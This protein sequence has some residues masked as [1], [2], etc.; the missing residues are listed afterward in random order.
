MRFVHRI[1][2]RASAV[3]RRVLEELALK[4]PTGASLP[5]GGEKL[6][7]FDVAE[8][9]PNWDRLAQLFLEW[10]VSDVLRTEFSKEDLDAARWLE[11]AAWH[12]GYP[13]PNEGTFGYRRATYDLSAWCE[14]CGV[15]KQQRAPFQMR[16]E[17]KWAGR[18]L[19]QLVWV[20]D[21]LFA[22]PDLWSRA[23]EPLGLAKRGVFNA[24]GAEL[25]TVVQVCVP[26]LVHV[27][28]GGLTAE[29]CGA[30]NREKFH[31]VARGEFPALREAPT[32]PMARTHEYFGSGAQADRRL[33]VSRDV[34]RALE[35]A[36]AR[37]AVLRPVAQGSAAAL[38]TGEAV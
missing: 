23:F 5:G 1:G 33:I 26:E 34:I 20:Y 17:P 28:Q 24:A 11:I 37:G 22:T 6:L 19:L 7:A 14:L 35:D 2:I 13:Q 9:H 8:D 25:K 31:P 18:S 21:E 32:T 29:R 16:G 15:G 38:T 30:C 10:R 3:Q 27:V 36:G 4:L 12:H